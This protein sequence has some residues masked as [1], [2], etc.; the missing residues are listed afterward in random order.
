M[1]L[2]QN[3]IRIF[4]FLVADSYGWCCS[5]I[6]MIDMFCKVTQIKSFSSSSFSCLPMKVYESE[7]YAKHIVQSWEMHCTCPIWSYLSLDMLVV[8]K[9]FPKFLKRF[10]NLS[11]THE[12]SYKVISSNLKICITNIKQNFKII[13]F[14]K[15]I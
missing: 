6:H 1:S 3:T 8:T 10:Q 2:N 9:I 15:N 12:S 14:L 5:L 7:V 4:L 13:T 11:A